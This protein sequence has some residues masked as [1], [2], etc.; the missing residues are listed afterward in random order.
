MDALIGRVLNQLEVLNLI[1]NTVIVFWG[2]HGFHL[3]EHGL[4]RK[5][6]L[7]D[8]A[9]HSPLIISVPGQAR[10]GAITDALV[11]LVDIYPTLCDICRLPISTELEGI[12]MLPVIERPNQPWKVAVFSQLRRGRTDGYSVRTG[13]YRYTEW[14]NNGEQGIELYD[15]NTHPDEAVNIANRS[16]NAVT[17]LSERLHAGWQAAVPN[18]PQRRTPSQTLRWDVNNDGVVDRHDLILI[19]NNL[20]VETPKNPKLDVNKDGIVDIVDLLIVT[21]HYGESNHPKAPSMLTP[22][23][24]EH[25]ALVEAWI[26]KARLA[27]DGSDVFR[28]GI[29]A[30]VGLLNRIVPEKTTLLPNYPNPFNPETWIPYDLAHDA[31]VYISI[32][33]LKGELIRQL[34]LGFQTAGT[35]RTA[36]RAAYWDG[37]N[38][39]NEPVAS[40]IY[41]YTL[42]VGQF[43][44]TRQMVILK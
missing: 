29:A 32:Y 9:L 19:A 37:R 31:E 28:H 42:Q 41:F 16:K 11:E 6:T 44:A 8:A 20:G 34:S 21:D 33:N 36:S 30:L 26:T 35:Y 2:D 38:G 24:P 15:Y 13:R 43:R 7:F 5:N 40:G 25:A 12:S 22:L 27:D 14:G 10:S 18:M 1:E 39:V 3:G 4:W 17:R 23:L